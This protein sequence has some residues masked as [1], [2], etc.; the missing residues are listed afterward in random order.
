LHKFPKFTAKAIFKTAAWRTKEATQCAADNYLIALKTSHSMLSGKT[1]AWMRAEFCKKGVRQS[2]PKAELVERLVLHGTKQPEPPQ[3]LGE[4]M[5]DESVILKDITAVFASGGAD[6]LDA[7]ILADQTRKRAKLQIK[8]NAEAWVASGVVDHINH[9]CE[10]SDTGGFLLGG[11]RKVTAKREVLVADTLYVQP[12]TSAPT[13][14]DELTAFVSDHGVS[15]LGWLR[16]REVCDITA[17]D[18]RYQSSL[19]DTY[20]TLCWC[21]SLSILSLSPR[22]CTFNGFLLYV[23]NTELFLTSFPIATMW[24]NCGLIQFHLTR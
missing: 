17:A 1:V 24:C 4:A 19:Q 8:T 20:C 5:P 10:G 21:C 13:Q 22:C 18:V 7:D 23:Y 14:S 2:G 3:I 11:L 12:A 16:C 15:V 9:L 6:D